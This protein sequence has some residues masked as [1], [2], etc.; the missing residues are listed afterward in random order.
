[1]T[2]Q[3][4]PGWYPDPGER[5]F[6][7]YWDG[8]AWTAATRGAS[9]GPSASDGARTGLAPM[10]ADRAAHGPRSAHRYGACGGWR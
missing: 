9:Q 7:R 6:E 1:V 5:A 4:P 3:P 8:R 2:G 10:P